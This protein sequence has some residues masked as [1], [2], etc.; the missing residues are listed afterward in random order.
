MIVVNAYP[1]N[2]QEIGDKFDLSGTPVF[3]W[4]DTIYAPGVNFKLPEDLMVHEQTHEI[5]QGKD[6]GKWWD[7]FIQDAS[8]RFDQELKA[9]QNQYKFFCKR[10]DRNKA[11]FFLDIIAEDL[12]GPMYGRMISYKTAFKLIKS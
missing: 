2:Y 12:S 7:R 10:H 8:F 3:T 11:F 1:P 9:Y 5:Q 4:G 6:P